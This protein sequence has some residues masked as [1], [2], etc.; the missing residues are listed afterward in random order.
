MKQ[1]VLVNTLIV[2]ASFCVIILV[3]AIV[4]SSNKGFELSDEAYYLLATKYP[5]DN[6][7]LNSS[8][9]LIN[10]RFCFGHIDLVSL[11]LF[12]LFYQFGFLLLFVYALFKYAKKHTLAPTN[13]LVLICVTILISGFSNYDYLP[14]TLSYNSW[15]LN[16]ALLFFAGLLILHTKETKFSHA[17]SSGVIGF[18]V[19]MLF[20]CKA[21]NA[22]ILAFVFLGYIF[23][24]NRKRVILTIISFGVGKLLGVL[25]LFHNFSLFKEMTS[26]LIASLITFNNAY[27][28]NYLAKFNEFF[29][30][31]LGSTFLLAQLVLIIIMYFIRKR[32]F[33]ALIGIILVIA[34][35]YF[36]LQFRKGNSEEI[37]NESK[38]LFVFIINCLATFVLFYTKPNL[39]RGEL[40]FLIILFIMPLLLAAGTSNP[41][42]FTTSQTMIFAICSMFLILLKINHEQ[43]IYVHAF[44]TLFV[45]FMIGS[46]LYHGMIL[47]PYRQTN[48]L[49][50]TAMLQNSYQVVGVKETD[51]KLALFTALA[52]KLK[53][54]NSNQAKVMASPPA[55]GALILSNMQPF[56]VFWMADPDKYADYN[57]DYLKRCDFSF[58]KP[59]LL[60]STQVIR[61][62]NHNKI[63]KNN[64]LDLKDGYSILDSIFLPLNSEYYYFMKP[65]LKNDEN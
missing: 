35:T 32:N 56:H 37:N 52:F 25:F 3:Y 9:G 47:N 60:L 29:F 11:R 7:L 57:N 10:F 13:T 20:Y 28:S 33:S 36:A 22:I 8:F 55:L 4:W 59:F 19:V 5:F 16:F 41:I 23:F 24:V 21:P 58:N 51:E 27:A 31:G 30:I 53:R 26:N 54:Y 50:K 49:S 6:L 45:C 63:F 42:F 18:A 61:S 48:L 40:F 12:K 38:V 39:K 44:L 64:G 15:S 14:M 46:F 34:N 43:L 2:L 1:N 65:K 62:V 17:I